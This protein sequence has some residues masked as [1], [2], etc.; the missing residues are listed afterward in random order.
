MGI[1]GDI[2]TGL[3]GGMARQLERNANTAHRAA[4][5]GIYN[6]RRLSEQGR[7]KMRMAEDK[8]RD[9]ADRARNIYETRK[10]NERG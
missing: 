2:L 10:S 7:E 8:Y 3:A 1:L 5:S 6:G 4:Q 9:A